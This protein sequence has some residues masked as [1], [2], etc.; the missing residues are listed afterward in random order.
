MQAIGTSCEVQILMQQGI[1]SGQ[2]IF[3]Y[4]LS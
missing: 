3:S 2:F 1:K 4:V